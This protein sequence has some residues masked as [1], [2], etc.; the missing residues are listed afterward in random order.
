MKRIAAAAIALAILAV[1]GAADARTTSVVSYPY[2]QVFPS[3]VR[4]LRIDEGLRITEKDAE[5]GYILFEVDDDGKTYRGSFEVARV[6]DQDGRDAS[7]IIVRI[8]DRPLYMEQGLVDRFGQK[9]YRELGDPAAPPA[10]EPPKPPKKKR[11]PGESKGD[12]AAP[13]ES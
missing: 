13:S 10:K 5:S 4:F 7:R 3:A 8:E 11:K 12:N 6:R 9:L 1:A 2:K